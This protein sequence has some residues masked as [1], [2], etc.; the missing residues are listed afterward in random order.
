[1][2]TVKTLFAAISVILLFSCTPEVDETSLQ[3]LR[4]ISFTK[5]LSFGTDPVIVDAVKIENKKSRM[6][7]EI[8]DLDDK[9]I[10]IPVT[11]LRMKALTGSEC[12][13]YL[14]KIQNSEPYYA[15]IFVMDKL[16]RN[17]CMTDK[18]SDYWQGDEAKFM[19]SY[20][21]GKGDVHISNVIFDES[22]DAY[23]IQ[24]SIPVIDR[25]DVIG[26]MTFSVDVDKFQ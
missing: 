25:R 11:A 24:V 15:E 3:K 18:T 21:E 10:E 20:K 16:G 12:G 19:E 1:M 17:V 8:K 23:V 9:W 7:S 4:N 6:L 22:A 26:A 2:Q 13:R 5:L 14:K